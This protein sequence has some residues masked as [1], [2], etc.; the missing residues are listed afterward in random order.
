[1]FVVHTVSQL[2]EAARIRA[3]EILVTGNLASKVQRACSLQSCIKKDAVSTD[4]SLTKEVLEVEKQDMMDSGLVSIT[5]VI[6]DYVLLSSNLESNS[7]SVVFG[8]TDPL[9][10]CESSTR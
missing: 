1:M 7:P 8:L 6:G 9:L 3:E 10:S 4:V 5:L 2:E